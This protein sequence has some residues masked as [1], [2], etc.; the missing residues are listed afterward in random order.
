MFISMPRTALFLMNRT[1]RGIH[2]SIKQQ[3][4]EQDNLKQVNRSSDRQ[5]GCFFPRTD[6]NI[7][8]GISVFFTPVQGRAA[9]GLCK[10]L[11]CA[12]HEVFFLKTLPV[13]NTT[14]FKSMFPISQGKK[15]GLGRQAMKTRVITIKICELWQRQQ[16]SP[17]K[18]LHRCSPSY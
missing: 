2:T 8:K 1:F 3:A 11:P 14:F 6:W 15:L 7:D 5:D 4:F 12:L 17:S 18:R 16:T 13:L 10:N 9:S